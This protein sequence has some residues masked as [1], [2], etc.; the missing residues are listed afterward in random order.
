MI[1]HQSSPLRTIPMLIVDSCDAQRNPGLQSTG[2]APVHVFT[3]H[4]HR[5]SLSLSSLFTDLITS[6]EQCEWSATVSATWPGATPSALLVPC[7]PNTINQAPQKMASSSIPILG[8]PTATAPTDSRPAPL[9]IAR[10]DSMASSAFSIMPCPRP[11]SVLSSTGPG[12]G[13][14]QNGGNSANEIT[15]N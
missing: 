2:R 12:S 11:S 3:L 13:G 1:V 7:E 5:Q 15:L 14:K 10:A 8:S 4:S 9:S 6:T